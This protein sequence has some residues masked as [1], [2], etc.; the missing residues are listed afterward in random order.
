MKKLIR[1]TAIIS[2]FTLSCRKDP[3][4][5]TDYFLFGVSYGHCINDCAYFYKL[6]NGKLYADDMK[7]FGTFSFF[8][9]E[10]SDS[11]AGM[12]Q[13]LLAQLPPVLIS[14]PGQTFGCPDCVDQGAYF[15]QLKQNGTTVH[16]R[17]DPST[18][19]LP[20]ELKAFA[21]TLGSTLNKLSR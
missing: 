6:E 15:V 8:S 18:D 21:D 19:Q 7:R 9:G 2:L 14:Q 17:I 4:P 3:K 11:K 10:L 1:L 13:N 16:W 20:A 5:D 12:A